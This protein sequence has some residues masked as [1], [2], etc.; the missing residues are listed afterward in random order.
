M[1]TELPYPPTYEY[2]TTGP[3][4]VSHIDTD[5]RP[6]AWILYTLESATIR[7]WAEAPNNFL[8][9][10]RTCVDSHGHAILGIDN[11]PPRPQMVG[12]RQALDETLRLASKYL[13]DEQ[14]IE[15][16]R[17]VEY[18]RAAGGRVL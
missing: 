17:T 8:P 9:M 4:M 5:G 3:W 18:V 15:V 7:F 16:L 6:H 2:E 14:Q 13:T 1:T 10:R 12:T 11:N